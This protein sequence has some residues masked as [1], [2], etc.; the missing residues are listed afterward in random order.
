MDVLTDLCEH[1]RHARILADRH[2][3]LSR[4]LPDAPNEEVLLREPLLLALPKNHMFSALDEIP[5]RL[6]KN[7]TFVQVAGKDLTEILQNCCRDGGFEPRIAFN[8]DYPSVTVDCVEM[9]LGI[10]LVPAITWGD[11]T[12]QN[13]ILRPIAGQKLT[14]YI[15]LSWRANTYRSKSSRLFHSFFVEYLHTHYPDAFISGTGDH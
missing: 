9:G 15:S 4:E 7:E 6:L 1:D 10:A 2:V 8:C 12:A 13:L 5:I 11:M 14:R 3:V